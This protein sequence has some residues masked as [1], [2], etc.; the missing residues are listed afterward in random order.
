MSDDF[1]E[2]F[3]AEDDTTTIPPESVL[4]VKVINKLTPK[5]SRDEEKTTEAMSALRDLASLYGADLTSQDDIERFK[6]FYTSTALR[7]DPLVSECAVLREILAEEHAKPLKNSRA[8]S[9]GR[10]RKSDLEA[11]NDFIAPHLENALA[12]LGETLDLD[13][14]ALDIIQEKILEALS[15]PIMRFGESKVEEHIEQDS[16]QF[17]NTER[18]TKLVG[19]ITATEKARQ[20]IMDSLGKAQVEVRFN[21]LAH[22]MVGVLE[23]TCKDPAVI[24]DFAI[25]LDALAKEE[26]LQ[27]QWGK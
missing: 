6:R 14:I 3:V 8:S 22:K 10:P 7:L 9:R 17:R 23:Q 4:P 26:G 19:Q 15:V 2:L 5:A 25:G 11:V 20:V 12:V 21:A 24:R 18:I 13:T 16:E 1:D 27:L